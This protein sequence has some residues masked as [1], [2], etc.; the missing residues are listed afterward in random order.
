MGDSQNKVKESSIEN[1]HQRCSTA[2]PEV[3]PTPEPES[4]PEPTPE[5]FQAQT[6]ATPPSGDMVYVEG[7][8]WIENQGP[9]HVEYAED[10]YENGN[11]V[12]IMG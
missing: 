12:G 7:F 3:Q 1:I 2:S 5:P 4:T 10:M 8:G 6:P 9:N 11:K